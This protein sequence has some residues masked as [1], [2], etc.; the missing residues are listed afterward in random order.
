MAAN[1]KY[2]HRIMRSM[3]VFV[4]L[5]A[6][7]LAAPSVGGPTESRRG[8]MDATCHEFADRP[9]RPP[10]SKETGSEPLICRASH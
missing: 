9:Q 4:F 7:G 6:I 1:G 8:G 2:G 5:L 3:A 10:T